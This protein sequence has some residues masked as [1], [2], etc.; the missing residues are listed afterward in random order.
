MGEQTDLT[1]PA[2]SVRVTMLTLNF[3][4]STIIIGLT[5]DQGAELTHFIGGAT[6]QALMIALNK[7]PLD[8]KSLHRR[9]MEKL[10]ADG[11]L[12]GTIS[13]TPD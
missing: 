7:A 8:T 13:G 11:V 9:I 3:K 6:A 4:E 10:I 2:A 5:S 1:V 12:A